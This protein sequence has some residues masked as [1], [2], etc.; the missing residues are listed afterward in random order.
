MSKKLK[1]SECEFCEDAYFRKRK[2]NI[3]GI[4]AHYES[5]GKQMK[6]VNVEE[7]TPEFCPLLNVSKKEIYEMM[8]DDRL[9]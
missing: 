9:T 8:R 2:F 7:E 5:F 1:C 3:C 4:I 6:V